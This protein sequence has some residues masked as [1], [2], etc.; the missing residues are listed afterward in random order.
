MLLEIQAVRNLIYQGKIQYQWDLLYLSHL[1]ATALY[2]GTAS[3]GKKEDFL[4]RCIQIGDRYRYS[5]QIG[6]YPST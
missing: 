3:I 5:I 2:L 4:I 6:N 1:P